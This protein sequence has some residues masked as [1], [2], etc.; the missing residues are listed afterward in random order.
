MIFSIENKYDAAQKWVHPAEDV[1]VEVNLVNNK[2]F[3]FPSQYRSYFQKIPRGGGQSVQQPCNE[4]TVDPLTNAIK[5]ICNAP[6]G[7][8][9]TDE[10]GYVYIGLDVEADN[11]A[12]SALSATAVITTST[13]KT[14]VGDVLSV[15][16]NVPVCQKSKFVI[17]VVPPSP[18]THPYSHP[19]KQSIY[20]QET[21]N[22]DLK[23]SVIV[24]NSGP[25]HYTGS[26]D[27]DFAYSAKY[28]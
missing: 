14:G 28:K 4:V 27:I 11:V 24:Y 13:A 2:E 12:S 10:Y 8:L 21:P 19:D 16:H 18:V 25:S 6:Q 26:G 1:Q 9:G 22:N 7:F 3:F 20:P 15:T 5:L 17:T 23:R